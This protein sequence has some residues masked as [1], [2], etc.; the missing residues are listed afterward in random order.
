MPWNF[1]FWQ[2]FR[3]AAPAWMA[4]NAVVLKHAPNTLGCGDAIAELM[5]DAGLPEGL[6]SHLVLD[7]VDVP[8]VIGD[9]RVRAVTLTGSARAGA[10]VAAE[11][12]RHLKK[13]VLE[14]GGSD[15]V[16]V[17]A[18]ADVALAAKTAAESRLVNSGQSCIAAK[19]FI[20][21]QDVAGP[22]VEAFEAH[23]RAAVVGHPLAAG[24]TVGPLAREDLRAG[25]HAQVE[26]SVARGARLAFGGVVPEG[27]GSFYPVTMLTGVGP[28]MPAWD[29]ETFGPVAAVRVVP[30]EEAAIG[31]ANDSPF[32][33]GASVWTA[34][35]GRAEALAH[36]LECGAVFVNGLV[37]S[38]PR[39]PFGGV[40]D[41]GYGREL[42]AAGLFEFVN[43]QTVWVR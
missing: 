29:E 10:A 20:V 23:L 30:H 26:R 19:R 25:L 17:L 11:A 31:A 27:P 43:L 13:S 38:D 32:G 41:S 1:P 34:D 22:F 5:L 3:A 33:L 4:G 18:D 35:V 8:G 21:V 40:K 37:K 16:V 39:L 6:L 24:T 14:L 28:G 7:L 42:G 12:G 2:V 36:R 9:R 15:P